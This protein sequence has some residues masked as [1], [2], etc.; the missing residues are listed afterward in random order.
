L[1]IILRA[2]G[3]GA[4]FGLAATTVGR[5]LALVPVV[6]MRMGPGP[7]MLLETVALE[8]ALGAALGIVAA[9]LLRLRRGTPIHVLTLALVWAGLVKWVELD[10]PLFARLQFVP[11]ALG[12]LLTGL[13]LW[14]GRR[15]AAIPLAL[16]FAALAGGVAAP[17]VYLRLT[18][19]AAAAKVSLPPPPEG[20]PDIVLIVL[21]TVR[22]QNLSIYGYA[23]PTSPTLEALAAEGALFLDAT[24]PSTW[25][26]ASHASLF[27]GR[28]P[29]G[30][31]AHWENLFLD[32]RFPTL[33]GVLA[34]RG[35]D[36]RCFTANA[37]ISDGLGL[38]RGFAWQDATW[39][40]AEAGRMFV[41]IHRLLARFGSE[42]GDK[43][44]AMVASH[45]AEWLRERPADA[46]PSFVFLNF[47]EAHFPYHQL[48]DDYLARYTT[49]P[50]PELRE[51]SLELMGAQ[52]GGEVRDPAGAAAPAL[53]MYDGGVLYSDH[54]L[55]RVLDALRE[56]GTLDRTVLIVLSDHGEIL[57]EHGD[58]FGHGP[59]LHEPMIRVPLLVRYPPRVAAGTRVERPVSTVG[60]YA[61]ILDLADI[62]PPP[63]LHVGS[64]LPVLAGEAGG[65]PV[66]SERHALS[67]MASG[68][69]EVSHPLMQPDWRYR[70]YRAGNWKLIETSRGETFLFDVAA[71]PSE[72]RNLAADQPFELA[73][74]EEDLAQVRAELGLPALDAAFEPSAAPELDAET[75]QR[76]RELG[77]VQ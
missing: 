66:L 46:R 49:R 26:L 10:T 63:T 13:G 37:W 21:D 2:L 43:G 20:A 45:F 30:H 17:A 33:A 31:G 76:L 74:L 12:A 8:I 70:A 41:F 18:A 53:N 52:F 60:V 50:R 27:T 51:I 23:R 9:P 4:A 69:V 32:D 67:A 61:T 22:A 5:W 64:L 6:R 55:G 11:P 42:P 7:Q 1:K 36:T 68:S 54:L 14:L 77:Y 24:S 72:S 29:S 75:T 39:K 65:G 16:A 73:R 15:R 19:P 34:S 57:G 38:T 35:Y 47:L 3:L 58:F 48:P 62:E 44:G 28:Y 59:S 56:R 25:S 71:D 40:S